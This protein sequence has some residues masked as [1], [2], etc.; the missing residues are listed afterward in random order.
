MDIK[1]LQHSEA[2]LA[3]CHA[4]EQ[5]VNEI[6][7]DD[8]LA[9]IDSN[10]SYYLLDV[11]DA[12]EYQKGHLPKAQH[13]SKGWIEAKIH[14]VVDDK[15]AKLVLY[16]GGGHRSLLAADNLRKMGYSG[17]LSMKGGFKQWCREEKPTEV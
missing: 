4:A 17:V 16:C 9:L 10:E 15:Q 11:R 5:H 1:P 6:S 3:L 7:T 2:F 8:V 13:L 14:Q 12:D